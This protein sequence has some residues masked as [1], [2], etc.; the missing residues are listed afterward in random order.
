MYNKNR[1]ICVNSKTCATL[2]QSN[3]S[4]REKNCD[5]IAFWCPN[6]SGL[7]Y[8]ITQWNR[9]TI[10]HSTP[11]WKLIK[12]ISSHKTFTYSLYLVKSRSYYYVVVSS[13]AH[14]LNMVSALGV[15]T[16][17]PLHFTLLS[18]GISDKRKNKPG[19]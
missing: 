15:N 14:H 5:L 10:K 7:E 4:H 2:T 13:R 8:T 6:I 18:T 9:L 17:L 19:P 1:I 11:L 3:Q 12:Y 16:P